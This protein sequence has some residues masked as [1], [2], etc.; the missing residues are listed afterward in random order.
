MSS[1]LDN[2]IQGNQVDSALLVLSSANPSTVLYLP[3]QK[4]LIQK[5]FSQGTVEEL[6]SFAPT[7]F[8]LNAT[9]LSFLPSPGKPIEQSFC[10]QHITEDRDEAFDLRSLYSLSDRSHDTAW[11][12]SEFVV[13]SPSLQHNFSQSSSETSSFT[14]QLSTKGTPKNSCDRKRPN[15][16]NVNLALKSLRCVD[17]L[18]ASLIQEIRRSNNWSFLFD[19]STS[20]PAGVLRAP[21]AAVLQVVQATGK[22]NRKINRNVWGV[23]YT[24]RILYILLAHCIDCYM[25]SDAIPV[26][27]NCGQGA[28]TYAYKAISQYTGESVSDIRQMICCTNKYLLLAR[29]LGIG[30]ILEIDA[31][32]SSLWERR[33][34]KNDVKEA[35]LEIG[36][37]MSQDDEMRRSD[38]DFQTSQLIIEILVKVGTSMPELA[39]KDS[40]LIPLLRKH[41]HFGYLEEK[42]IVWKEEVLQPEVGCQ[43]PGKVAQKS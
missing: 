29:E 11:S 34:R 6:F 28:R 12:S 22:I 4:S 27:K 30:R 20:E 18:P 1:A 2:S 35:C 32:S 9:P 13:N 14:D 21:R 8:A 39:T 26:H 37:E 36:K 23:A 33:L 19:L 10:T 25:K 31:R 16:Q 41:I 24:S 38:L 40:C 15:K 43:Q 7:Q 3:H 42:K 17:L 5:F